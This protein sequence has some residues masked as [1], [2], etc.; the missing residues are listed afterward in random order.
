MAFHKVQ[1]YQNTSVVPDEVLIHRIGLM[2]LKVDA[3]E[4]VPRKDDDDLNET[5]SLKFELR[6]KCYKKP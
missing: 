3:K 5:N 1:M 2:P 6:V 4:F